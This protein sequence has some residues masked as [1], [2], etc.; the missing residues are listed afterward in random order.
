M[1]AEVSRVDEVQVV[2]NEDKDDEKSC[3]PP[4]DCLDLV[5][6]DC[7]DDYILLD[8]S[9][10]SS[11][12]THPEDVDKIE[13][14]ELPLIKDERGHDAE[15]LNENVPLLSKGD[16][17]I[18]KLDCDADKDTLL[19]TFNFSSNATADL[20]NPGNIVSPNEVQIEH[21]DNI[22]TTDVDNENEVLP[23][24]KRIVSVR[25][26]ETA[27]ARIKGE[28]YV[29]YHKKDDGT[30]EHDVPRPG[31]NLGERCLHVDLT[32]KSPR[33]YMCGAITEKDREKI[34]TEFWKL[35]TWEAKRAMVKG[36]TVSREA[37]RRRCETTN[38]KAKESL[39]DCFLHSY[40]AGKVRVC[41]KLFLST[42]NIRSNQF[43]LWTSEK[44][45]VAIDMDVSVDSSA[46]PSLTSNLTDPED[47][48]RADTSLASNLTEP[49]DSQAATTKRFR[50]QRN[51]QSVR[52]WLSLLRS[53]QQYQV[54]TVVLRQRRNT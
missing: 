54:I 46:G 23:R 28:S 33:S 34:F 41:K 2:D 6:V 5:N 31:R 17:G 53:Y 24:K 20:H 32:A 11:S 49:E 52:D 13:R 45:S 27:V 7:D 18:F 4:P 50:H 38:D 51:H 26:N 47:H 8:I 10:Y 9:N 40:T 22:A 16:E 48:C 37:V 3:I 19:D 35:S 36:L 1:F 25:R 43:R 21:D 29:G 44:S 39:H 12:K 30:I 15:M 14:R 42:L